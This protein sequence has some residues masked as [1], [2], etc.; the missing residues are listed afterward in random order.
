MTSHHGGAM[1][2]VAAATRTPRVTAAAAAHIIPI[3]RDRIVGRVSRLRRFVSLVSG[4]RSKAE[5]AVYPA[6]RS[7]QANRG[8]VCLC[9]GQ[10]PPSRLRCSPTRPSPVGSRKPLSPLRSCSPPSALAGRRGRTRARRPCRLEARG[11]S[12]SPRRRSLSS[13]SETPRG[14]TF[15]ALRDEVSIPARLLGLGLPLTLLVG[16]GVGLVLLGALPWPGGTAPCRGPRSHRRGTR[17]GRGHVAPAA[18]PACARGSTSR[19]G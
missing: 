19:A 6:S 9:T 11:S 3:H 17:P 12:F 16:F 4:S 10:C 7:R 5:I 14:S 1:P 15:R 13:S 18:V 8:R 2:P